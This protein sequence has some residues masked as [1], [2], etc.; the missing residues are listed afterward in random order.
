MNR[1][2]RAIERLLFALRP[3][4]TAQQRPPTA[5]RPDAELGDR[6]QQT[7]LERAAVWVELIS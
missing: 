7:L 6:R 5:L 3:N 4:D 1:S 2:A